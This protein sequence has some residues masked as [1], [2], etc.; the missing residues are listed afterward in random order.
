[1]HAKTHI[2]TNNSKNLLAIEH[3]GKY[4]EDGCGF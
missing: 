3:A 4:D 2:E 1:M